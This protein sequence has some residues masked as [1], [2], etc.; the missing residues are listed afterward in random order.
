MSSQSA[1]INETMCLKMSV[2]HKK[3]K[4]IHRFQCG[5]FISSKAT[6]YPTMVLIRYEGDETVAVDLPHGNSKSAAKLKS[7]FVRARPSLLATIKKSEGENPVKVY[8]RLI[9]KVPEARDTARVAVDT[10]RDIEM[11]RNAHASV[12]RQNNLS[13]DSIYNLIEIAKETG[14]ILFYLLLPELVIVAV[15]KGREQMQI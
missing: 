10:P 11:V 2:T 15:H 8:D 3:L 14:F 7:V 6:Q 9:R 1:T 4:Q 12:R 13:Q 5:D